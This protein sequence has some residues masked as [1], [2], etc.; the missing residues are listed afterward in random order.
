MSR[1]VKIILCV[2]GFFVV[3]GTALYADFVNFCN[4]SVPV[5][6]FFFITRDKDIYSMAPV[7][8]DAQL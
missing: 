5:F 4:H 1:V 8:F 2:F 6:F 7:V 3:V